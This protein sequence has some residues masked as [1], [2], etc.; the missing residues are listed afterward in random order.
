METGCFYV[1]RAE[2]LQEGTKFSQFCT[3]VCEKRTSG[4]GRGIAVG[5]VTRKRL[6]TD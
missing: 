6:V 2:M 4:G 3:E 1:V 5:A